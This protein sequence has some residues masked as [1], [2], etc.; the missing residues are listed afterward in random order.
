MNLNPAILRLALVGVVVGAAFVPSPDAL[1]Q[2]GAQQCPVVGSSTI[3]GQVTSPLLSETS[4]ITASRTQPGVYWIHN[5]S[6]NSNHLYGIDA[7]GDLL[8]QVG[9]A[10]INNWDFEDIAIGPGPDATVDYI[11]VA[12]I[13]ANQRGRDA[14]RI[15]RLEEP[16]VTRGVL[17]LPLSEID[18]FDFSYENPTGPGTWNRNAES[19][20]VDPVTGDIVVIEKH[21][22]TVNGVPNASW[23][24]RIRQDELV[25]DTTIIAKPMV[26]ARVRYNAGTVASTAADFSVDGKV[27]IVKN[28][29]E[30][31]AWARN[32]NQSIFDAM[33][34][35]PESDCVFN[36][37]G[38]E[39]ITVAADGS[40][41][42]SIPEGNTPNVTRVAIT[43]PDAGLTCM[44]VMANLKGTSGNDTLIG[45]GK[46]DVIHGRAGNDRIEGRGGPD[47]ICG[48]GGA[49]EIYGNADGDRM[50]GGSG[51]DVIRGGPGADS[52]RGND[53]ADTLYG[54][55][56]P[57][58]IRGGPGNDELRGGRGWDTL[59]GGPGDDVCGVGGGTGTKSDC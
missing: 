44:G 57:D 13:G 23:V 14:V 51:A 42:Y 38:G 4:G 58:G 5:D 31:V 2:A 54:Q 59:N 27:L 24:Y 47:L 19:F 17:N 7:S 41:L 35:N 33:S 1:G 21:T 28:H 22:Q 29:N 46:R 26:A 34:R 52:V 56:G 15:Y 32:A 25:T 10:D 40:A 18:R 43:L 6:G 50:L 8:M 36:G 3:S 48:G 53:G 12:D 55:D 45:T 9:L 11:Y 39:A 49:D 30:I 20:A 37:P 16:K